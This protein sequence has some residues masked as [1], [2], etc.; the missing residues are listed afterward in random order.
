MAKEMVEYTKQN[1]LAQTNINL[2]QMYLD[3]R[4]SN[5]K[6]LLSSFL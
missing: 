5:A 4:E 3:V 1:L 2:L 6:A